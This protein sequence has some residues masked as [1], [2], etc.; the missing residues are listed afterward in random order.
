MVECSYWS[1]R[2]RRGKRGYERECKNRKD[3][4]IRFAGELE[5]KGREQ[6][7]KREKR[8]ILKVKVRFGR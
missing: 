5:K 8:E 7:S 3:R 1:V 6:E 4:R 2:K